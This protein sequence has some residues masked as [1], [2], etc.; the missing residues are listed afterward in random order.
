MS[1]LSMSTSIEKLSPAIL[2]AKKEMT[3]AV[4]DS[5]NPFFKSKFADLNSV[6]EACEPALAKNGVSVLQPMVQKDGKTFVRTMLLHESG[7]YLCSDTEVV[8]AKQNDPQAYGSAI[9]Y[10]RRYGLQS[11]VSLG[12]EDNDAEGAMGRSLVNNANTAVVFS[13]TKNITGAVTSFNT[14]ADTKPSSFK[15]QPKVE[16][17]KVE[18]WD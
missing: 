15:K 10:A 16:E 5:K 12:A 7:Q 3:N 11:L 18:G 17:Q 8:C 9:S 4:K 6:R 13:D 14:T 1:D 2:A